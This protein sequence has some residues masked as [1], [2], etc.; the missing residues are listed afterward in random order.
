MGHREH[1]H[2]APQSVGLAL[3]TVSTS[4]AIGQDRSGPVMAELCA[5]AGQRVV[6]RRLVADG[7][8]PIRAVLAELGAEEEIDAVFLSGGSGIS[9]Q[10]LTLEALQ[11]LVRTWLPGFGELFRRLSFDE[12]GTP[13]MLSRAAAAVCRLGPA[14]RPVLVAAL[15]GSPNAVRLALETVLLPELGH[16]I[17]E[18]RR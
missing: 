13:A 9:S 6:A 3:V 8:E 15:P 11:P 12:I 4:R 7:L 14:Q 17:Y 10:D 1:K 18:M 2:M 16:L 5:A